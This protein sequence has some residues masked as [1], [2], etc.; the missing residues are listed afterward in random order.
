MEIPEFKAVINPL[1]QTLRS[2]VDTDEEVD[3]H[4][5]VDAAFFT[6]FVAYYH[7]RKEVA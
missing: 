1:D 2:L 4:M 7:V 5:N 3:E 6:N